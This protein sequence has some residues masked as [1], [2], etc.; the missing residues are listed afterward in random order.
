MGPLGSTLGHIQQLGRY[1]VMIRQEMGWRA[2]RVRTTQ[3]RKVKRTKAGP[4]YSR[5]WVPLNEDAYQ[6]HARQLRWALHNVT[7]LTVI[8]DADSWI[9]NVTTECD[10]KCRSKTCAW[11]NNTATTP[12]SSSTST[13]GSR[14]RKETNEQQQALAP[15]TVR[16]SQDGQD[17]TGRNA[18]GPRLILDAEGGTDWLAS[19]TVEWNPL[20][21][22][23][24]DVDD[25]V[26][27][28][29]H[30]T[31]WELLERINRALQ[32][33]QH[34]FRSVIL[35]SI[36]ELQ[37]QAKRSV[38][39]QGMKLQDWGTLYDKMDPVLRE[40]RDLTKAPGSP[41]ECVVLVALANT[42]DERTIPDIQGSMAR[43]LAGQMDTIG[44]L[45]ATS[46]NSDGTIDRET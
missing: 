28:V 7:Q 27:V 30:I 1:A 43:S 3:I 12:K 13:T 34:P 39:D 17:L 31:E 5:P 15:T 41:V 14:A 37:K 46:M 42:K 33:G 19:K 21:G 2:N 40:I 18:P 25:D 10:W 20:D 32:K 16:R 29:V 24:P 36:T 35:D 9:F 38:T 6:S 45:R 11:L 44:Y 26:S 22:A 4:F 23:P 8:E